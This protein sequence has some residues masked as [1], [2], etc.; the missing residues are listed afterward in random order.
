M[1]L[2]AL[3]IAPPPPIAFMVVGWIVLAII[4]WAVKRYSRNGWRI[5]L[6]HYFAGLAAACVLAGLAARYIQDTHSVE[7]FSHNWEA[8]NSSNPNFPASPSLTAIPS[9][10]LE[11]FLYTVGPAIVVMG[12]SRWLKSQK[13]QQL[14]T[15]QLETQQLE[16]QLETQ[17]LE[18]H[19]LETHQLETEQHQTTEDA[20]DVP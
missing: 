3:S 16:T 9:I 12:I 20:A 17:Q 11:L 10:F 18:T 5:P 6:W 14:E 1:S 7:T 2:L 19:Q 15:Q 4:V 8:S 13:T